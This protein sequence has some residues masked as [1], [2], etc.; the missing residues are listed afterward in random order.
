VLGCVVLQ[1]ALNRLNA[2]KWLSATPDWRV[3][4]FTVGVT[5]AA[6]VLFGLAPALQIAR[7]R[8]RKTLARQ[9]LMGAQVA[10]SCVLLIVSGLLVRATQKAL[11]SDPG[12]GYEQLLSIDAQLDRYGYTPEVAKAYLEQM[13][14][15]LRALPSVRSVSLVNLPPMGHAVSRYTTVTDGHTLLIYPNSVSPG[16]FETMG[17]PLL[18]GRT[19]YAGEKNAVIVSESMARLQWPGQNPLGK[20]IEDSKDIVVGVA[21]NAPI[22]ALSNDD[23]LE[24]YWAV[25]PEEMAGMVV[26]VRTAGAPEVLPAAA[27]SISESLDP[28]LFPEIR[29]MKVLYHDSVSGAEKTAAVVSLIGLVAVFVAGVGILG[30][31]TY[32]VSQRTKEI[33]IRMALGAPRL[34]VLA[35]VLRQF[36]WP[37]LLGLVVGV[38]GTAAVSQ[39]LRQVLYGVSNLDP[40]S[41]A[42]AVALLLMIFMLAAVLPARRA[43]KLDIARALHQE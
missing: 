30:M 26:M 27:K 1:I 37:A 41:Y 9:I 12:F 21:G 24:E 11:Y 19:F 6:T 38:G 23:A 17:I 7:Q 15:R 29:Q 5:V 34:Q 13:Q 31:V 36:S 35:S 10:A 16:Y 22:N 40:L 33:A 42:A 39:I 14:S 20:Q 8:H 4:A 43:L 18:L 32:T 28:K 3:L 2:P 25:K